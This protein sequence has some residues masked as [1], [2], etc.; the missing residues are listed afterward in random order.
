LTT[1]AAVALAA[2]LLALPAAPAQPS[3]APLTVAV[4]G[5]T[6][7]GDEQ[8]AASWSSTTTAGRP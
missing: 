3:T 5:D 8:V 2:I 1:A 4:I 6:P 7:Y